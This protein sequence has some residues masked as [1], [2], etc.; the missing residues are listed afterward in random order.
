MLHQIPK[1][2]IYTMS[3]LFSH[4]IYIAHYKPNSGRKCQSSLKVKK[5]FLIHKLWLHSGG[6]GISGLTPKRCTDGT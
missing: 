4:S 2:H 1:T 6:G 5:G 3:G